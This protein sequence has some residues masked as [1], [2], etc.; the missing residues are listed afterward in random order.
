MH[1]LAVVLVVLWGRVFAE[2][3][4]QAKLFVELGYLVLSIYS[5]PLLGTDHVGAF[6]PLHRYLDGGRDYQLYL[7]NTQI[8]LKFGI[9]CLQLRYLLTLSRLGFVD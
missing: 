7:L 5:H 6:K 2:G 3:S 9:N 4:H 8:K 1:L